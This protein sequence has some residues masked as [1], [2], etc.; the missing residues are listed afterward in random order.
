LSESEVVHACIKWLHFHGCDVIRNNTTAFKNTYTRKD[1]TQGVSWVRSDKKGSGDILACS[2]HGRWIEVEC[3]SETG[4][5]R[6]EQ[7]TRQQEITK[8]AGIYIIARS[9]DDL[10]ARKAEI[11]GRERDSHQCRKS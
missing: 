7:I 5:L 6:P 1:G 9:I 11:L 10:E 8:R 3:K 4:S 2:P